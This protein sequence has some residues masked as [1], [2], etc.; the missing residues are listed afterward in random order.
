MGFDVRV[1]ISNETTRFC[2]PLLARVLPWRQSPR[3]LDTKTTDLTDFRITA[4]N[5]S[6]LRRN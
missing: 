6:A 1:S 4:I 5:Y 3:L 2:C